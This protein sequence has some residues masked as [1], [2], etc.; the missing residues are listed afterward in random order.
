MKEKRKRKINWSRLILLVLPIFLALGLLGFGGYKLL[1]MR[2]DRI[3]AVSRPDT[4]SEDV[5]NELQTKALEDKRYEEVFLHLDQYDETILSFLIRDEDRMDFVLKYPQRDS[6]SQGAKTLNVSLEEFPL[7]LQWDIQWGY[8]PYGDGYIYQFGCAP[9]CLS[10]VFSYLKQDNSITP[11][12]LAQYSMEKG[13][14]VEGIGTDWSLLNEA[15]KDFGVSTSRI[16]VVADE[17]TNCLN[18]GQI[19]VCSMLPGDFTTEGHFIVI[20]SVQDGQFS[21]K[22]PNSKKNTSKLWDIQTV[23]GQMQAVWAYSV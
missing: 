6:Y 20:D 23:L 13:Y 2:T 1:H 9:T 15:G 12:R 14:Y 18:Q 21:I 3:L 16:Q 7:V 4:I 8:V 10:M 22:D 19:L 5:F 11:S 17:M